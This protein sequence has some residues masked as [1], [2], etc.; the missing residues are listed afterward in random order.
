MRGWTQLVFWPGLLLV[1]LLASAEAG[2]LSNSQK[3]ELLNAHN[4]YRRSVEPSATNMIQLVRVELDYTA[5]L[6]IDEPQ[7]ECLFLPSTMYSKYGQSKNSGWLLLIFH[8]NYRMAI[9]F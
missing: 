2:P 4:L 1:V 5:V 8:G 6:P 3:K 7:G 9:K